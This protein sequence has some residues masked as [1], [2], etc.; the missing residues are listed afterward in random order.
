MTQ[1]L[2]IIASPFVI[3][4]TRSGG[5]PFKSFTFSDHHSDEQGAH[6]LC[7]AYYGDEWDAPGAL[8]CAFEIALTVGSW[9]SSPLYNTS[10][11]TLEDWFYNQMVGYYMTLAD[12][13]LLMEEFGQS[14]TEHGL[15]G[16]TYS[17]TFSNVG[18][19]SA[20]A[21]YWP[22]EAPFSPFHTREKAEECHYGRVKTQKHSGR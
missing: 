22:A 18:H 13:M 6:C 20:R 1:T 17:N 16:I 8:V 7:P 3:S 21:V 11:S 19:G 15:A 14:W 4:L 2:V 5:L 10:Y 12:I 9:N